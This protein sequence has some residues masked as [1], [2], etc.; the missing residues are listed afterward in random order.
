MSAIATGDSIKHCVER[1][2]IYNALRSR[3]DA[4]NMHGAHKKCTIG[5][6]RKIFFLT[7]ESGMGNLG[8][9]GKAGSLHEYLMLLHEKY[10]TIA[11]FWWAKTYVVSVAS[12]EYW[13]ELQPL[14]DRPRK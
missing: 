2:D 7:E 4:E 9:M 5:S 14:F 1:E 11:G 6:M 8:D 12:P 10:G 3:Q 13:K